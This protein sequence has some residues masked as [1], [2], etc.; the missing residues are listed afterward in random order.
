M[1][2]FLA[3]LIAGALLAGSPTIS[4]A[5]NDSEE[6]RRLNSTTETLIEGQESLRKQLQDLRQELAQLRSENAALKQQL[7]GVGHD[8]VSRPELAKVVEQVREVD[9]KRQADAQL[10]QRQLKDIAELVS[11]P[12]PVPDPPKVR[13]KA[14]EPKVSEKK[15]DNLPPLPTEGYEHVVASGESI[16]VIIAAYNQK[17]QLKVRPADVMRANPKLK[18]PKKIFVGQK[19]W[20]PEIK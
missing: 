6:I 2:R 20:I 1:K 3:P 13:E 10:V 16:G 5:Q 4:L 17:Y 18:D 11:K 14:P 12:I 7:A 15:E 9:T 19:L 8:N